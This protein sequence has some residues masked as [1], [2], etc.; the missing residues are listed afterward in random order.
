MADSASDAAY[1]S[2]GPKQVSI[3]VNWIVQSGS[4]AEVCVAH[5]DHSTAEPLVCH[6]GSVTDLCQILLQAPSN[7]QVSSAKATT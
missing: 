5:R 3:S 7:F 4:V 6:R 2:V 1:V